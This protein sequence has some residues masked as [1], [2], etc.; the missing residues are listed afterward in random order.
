MATVLDTLFRA[1]ATS[2][3]AKYGKQVVFRTFG[4][5]DYDPATGDVSQPGQTDRTRKI[6]VSR[7]GARDVDGDRIRATD[8]QVFAA[9]ADFDF[10]VD[11]KSAV[12]LDGQTWR[13]EG[14]IKHY[15]GDQVALLEI[16]LR[17]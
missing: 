6:L 15:S 4:S 17:N 11:K 10:E 13:V 9:A 3:I 2:L 14:V 16:Q 5:E 7:Y 8:M 12:V 1:K